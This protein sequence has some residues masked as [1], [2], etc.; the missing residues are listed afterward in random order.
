MTRWLVRSVLALLAAGYW[1]AG[2]PQGAAAAEPVDPRVEPVQTATDR[3]PFDLAT[4][5]GRVTVRP[6]AA[7]DVSARVAGAE[8]YWIDRTAFLSPFD[9]A[10]LWGDAAQAPLRDQL[11]YSQSWRFFFWRTTTPVDTGYLITHTANVHL[12]PG[13]VNVR[14]ALAT[15][16]AGDEVRL[17]GLL[18]DV[19]SEHG[20]SWSTSLVRNDHGD[21]GCEILWVE[22]VQIGGRVYD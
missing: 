11:D 7:F 18:V 21:H 4:R 20:L 14:R 5:R 1:L 6:R 22:S 8:P 3:A 10:L 15:V 13:G 17:R 12:I 2:R 19:V 9:F 16:D